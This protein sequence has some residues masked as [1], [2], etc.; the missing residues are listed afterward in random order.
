M[1]ANFYQNTKR[2]KICLY[3][4]LKN[5]SVGSHQKKGEKGIFTF[6]F[7]STTIL[8]AVFFTLIKDKKANS[9]L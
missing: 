6:P 8:F 1:E 5:P 2:L 7:T 3:Q 4:L 9:N